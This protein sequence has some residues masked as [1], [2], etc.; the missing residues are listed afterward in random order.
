MRRRD[1]VLLADPH[2]HLIGEIWSEHRDCEDPSVWE[3]FEDFDEQ[4]EFRRLTGAKANQKPRS[5]CS[6]EEWK[7]VLSAQRSIKARKKKIS[8]VFDSFPADIPI[9]GPLFKIVRQIADESSTLEEAYQEWFK[10]LERRVPCGGRCQSRRHSWK[11]WD[12]DGAPEPYVSKYCVSTLMKRIGNARLLVLEEQPLV[13]VW[14]AHHH[15]VSRTTNVIDIGDA[16]STCHPPK[17]AYGICQPTGSVRCCELADIF[18]QEQ[19]TKNN[20]MQ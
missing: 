13:M 3:D 9:G 10:V 18:R 5:N 1:H 20:N 7:T 6:P 8:E 2:P 12:W 15:A 19:H 11:D 17:W 4:E 14:S 16:E